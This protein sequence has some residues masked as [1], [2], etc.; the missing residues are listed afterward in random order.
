MQGLHGEYGSFLGFC[1][2][3]VMRSR[4]LIL[5]LVVISVT[6]G[7]C[8]DGIVKE[9]N[10]QLA[11]GQWL[12]GNNNYKAMSYSGDRAVNRTDENSPSV[13]FIKEDMKLLSAMGVKLIR[14]YNSNE[15]P[16]AVNLLEAIRE[17]KKCHICQCVSALCYVVGLP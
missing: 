1:K 6:L 15:F 16:Q 7:G 8:F 17:L 11:N 14:T 10:T 4:F 5:G 2:G 9:G 12:L 3:V 13:A